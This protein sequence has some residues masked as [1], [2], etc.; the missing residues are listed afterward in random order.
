[1]LA[2]QRDP[3]TKASV[4]PPFGLTDRSRTRSHRISSWDV[5]IFHGMSLEEMQLLNEHLNGCATQY[6][7]CEGDECS[8]ASTAASE[9]GENVNTTCALQ[10][11]HCCGEED[12][13]EDELEL[14]QSQVREC[15][16]LAS[17]PVMQPPGTRMLYTVASHE[18]S[19]GVDRDRVNNRTEEFRA[20]NSINTP[21][22]LTWVVDA[23]KLGT[24][25]QQIISPSFEICHQ[26]SCRLMVK[27]TSMGDKK[28]QTTFLKSSGCGSIE[29]KL[30]ESEGQVSQLGISL[31]VGK[32]ARAQA[33]PQ[34]VKHD[35]RQSSVCRL[36][37]EWDF[38]SVIDAESSTFHVFVEV[39]L[40][41]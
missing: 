35:F 3:V 10:H 2:S 30:V 19:N 9:D 24:R 16:I 20:S 18:P 22:L 28:R 15:C 33:S 36:G 1:M 40:T 38:R 14:S 26:T 7:S 21:I 11:S 6:V 27:P 17:Q 13:E 4:Q 29:F 12:E 5:A 8:S 41:C 34:I 37:D 39:F 32:G 31:S 23:K 25:D